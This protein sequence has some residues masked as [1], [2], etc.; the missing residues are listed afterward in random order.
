MARQREPFPDWPRLMRRSRAAAYCSFS[1]PSFVRVCPVKPID[2]GNGLLRWDR[3]EIDE[4]IDSL[5]PGARRPMTEDEIAA[6]FE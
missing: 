3:L 6:M 1:V 5:R 2:L 4:W